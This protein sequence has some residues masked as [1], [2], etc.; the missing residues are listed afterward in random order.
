MLAQLSLESH[1]EK[2]ASELVLASLKLTERLVCIV[3]SHHLQASADSLSSSVQGT[4]YRCCACF[5]SVGYVL[6]VMHFPLVRTL[7]QF[8]SDTFPVATK[9]S[10]TSQWKSNH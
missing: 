7:K 2:D 4:V 10:H 5:L 1:D 9:D 3:N 8:S 6:T